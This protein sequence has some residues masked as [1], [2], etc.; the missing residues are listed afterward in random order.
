MI[1]GSASLIPGIDASASALEA[2]KLRMEI[3][4]Q[5][6]ANAQ[7]TRGPNGEPY[8]RKMV[9]F[10]AA[11][12]HAMG[13]GKAGGVQVSGVE[14]DRRPGLEVYQPEHP[15]ADE[16]GMLRLPNVEMS[17]EM[18]DLLVSSR[19]YEANLVAVRT[20]REMAQ[21]TLSIGK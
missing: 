12:Q 7:V 17:R 8:Q 10:E 9:V 15:H 5:N 2:E 1:N 20:S 19:A 6:I 13:N 21:R 11:L 3:I 18:V 14:V 4:A 16:N